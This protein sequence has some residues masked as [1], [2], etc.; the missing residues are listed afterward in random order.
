MTWSGFKKDVEGAAH[1]GIDHGQ[2]LDIS[3]AAYL[4]ESNG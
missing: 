4:K 1:K 2:A 3:C